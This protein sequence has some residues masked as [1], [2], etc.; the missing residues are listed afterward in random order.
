M[1]KSENVKADDI[2]DTSVNDVEE[3][4]DDDDCYDD[5]DEFINDR[6]EYLYSLL[7]EGTYYEED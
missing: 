4:D 5:C 3:A 6:A 1:K 2:I 7:R